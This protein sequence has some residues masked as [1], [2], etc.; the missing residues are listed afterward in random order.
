M[1]GI[2]VGAGVVD[3][4]NSEFGGGKWGSVLDIIGGAT[5]Y[6]LPHF[7]GEFLKAKNVRT[8]AYLL[9]KTAIQNKQI[10]GI[11][12]N[13][14][15][16]ELTAIRYKI[17]DKVISIMPKD[18]IKTILGR[19]PDKADALA[20]ANLVATVGLVMGGGVPFLAIKNKK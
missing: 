16:E 12:D 8:Q 1:D 10:G 11:V 15:I 7:G 19:S 13:E 2:G 20:Y 3:I 5:P 18:A 6:D 14:L 9:L 17:E 4:L